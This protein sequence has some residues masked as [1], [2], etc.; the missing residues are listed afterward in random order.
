MISKLEGGRSRWTKEDHTLTIRRFEVDE[1]AEGLYS[2]LKRFRHLVDLTD[3]ALVNEWLD[4]VS[5]R[6][7]K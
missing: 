2:E 5:T 1:S 6:T 7:E 3:N 4:W